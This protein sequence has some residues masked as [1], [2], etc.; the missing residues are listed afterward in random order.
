MRPALVVSGLLMAVLVGGLVFLPG[1]P[2]AGAGP[3]PM[4]Y[5]RDTCARC[6]MRISQPGQGGELRDPEGKLTKYDDVGCLLVALW[7]EHREVTS[8]WVEDHGGGGF[9]PLTAAWFVLGE[10]SESP[11]GFGVTAFQE[12]GAARA[13]ALQHGGTV[14][15]LEDVLRDT[16]RFQRARASRE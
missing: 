3:E 11:M 6:R 8:A 2:D 13:H 5:D 4:Q 16:A 12:E 14:G 15:R 1:G 7:S 9:V 10:A